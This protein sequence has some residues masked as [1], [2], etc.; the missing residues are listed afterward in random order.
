MRYKSISLLGARF[1]P[2]LLKLSSLS[3]A[4][5][6]ALFCFFAV[7]G[8][9][10][11]T[12]DS[13]VAYSLKELSAGDANLTI[14][15]SQVVRLTSQLSI[16]ETSLSKQTA[17]ITNRILSHELIYTQLSDPHGIRYFLG[18]SESINSGVK[19]LSGRLPSNCSPQ[20]C[21]VIQIGRSSGGVPRPNSVGLRIVGTGV[22]IN[23]LLFSGTMAPSA[24][25][26][27]LLTGDSAGVKT[28]AAFTNSH[29]SDAWVGSLD[30]KAI[31][32]LGVDAFIAK[33][34]VFED[35]LSIDY[36]ELI[37]TWPEDALSSAS[38]DA[39]ALKEKTSLLKFAI[40][41]LLLGYLVI[42]AYRQRRDHSRFR[43]SL[44]R[45][46]TPKSVITQ[47][48]ILESAVPIKIGILIALALSPLIPWV[49]GRF[50]YHSGYLQIFSGT[51]PFLLVAVTAFSLIVAITL[52]G[53][54]AWRPEQ[55]G[56]ILLGAFA[57]EGYLYLTHSSDSRYL[58]LPFLYLGIP[59][60]GVFIG[61]R[62][63]TPWL[64]PK[65]RL[66]FVIL[67]EF[68]SLWH[69]V[70]AT[71]ALAT[72]LAM[73]TLSF[74]SGVSAQAIASAHD[75]VPLDVALKTGPDLV[76]P[77]DL[78]G[79]KGYSQLVA[80]SH[81][82]GVLRTGTSIRGSGAV[83]D[84][85]SLIGTDPAA[86]STLVPDAQKMVKTQD[87][88]GSTTNVGL[89]IGKTKEISVDL[90]GIPPEIDLSAWVINSHG[91]HQNLVFEGSGLTRTLSIGKQL[92]PDSRLIAFDF[93]ES[94]NYL[95]RRLHA[96]GEGDYSVP[97]IKGVGGI[98]SLKFDGVE[99]NLPAEL[100]SNHNF[101]Y[102]FDGQS[103]YIQPKRSGGVPEAIVDPATA[104]LASQGVL[105]LSGAKNTYFQVTVGKVI[106]HF[107]SAGDRFVI[108]S[109]NQMQSELGISDLGSIDPIEVWVSTP[110]SDQY[111][112]RLQSGGFGGLV[113]QGSKA[114]EAE[115]RAN[116]RDQ[117]ILS[118]YTVALLFALFVALLV[119]VSALPLLYREG[120]SA[121]FYLESVGSTP[122]E[123][124]KALRSTLRIG[125]LV[126]LFLGGIMGIAVS[127][128]YISNSIPI[129][130]QTAV[131]FLLFVSV[132]V[133]GWG[134]TQ[135][136][137]RESNSVR[138]SS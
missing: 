15:S 80:G 115:Y 110:H 24:G 71:V 19:V 5:L 78:D 99:Q 57:F 27:L 28:L 116:P 94:S 81:A 63:L 16:I 45:V 43:E 119:V 18:A 9:S 102:D 129:V 89:S 72:L 66:S 35:Q 87:F 17:R 32:A 33:V 13:L 38:S 67:K 123:L 29:G 3:I 97:Q 84:S 52:V 1:R 65:R 104:A 127:R 107:P 14:N 47:E 41:T 117:G 85:L 42:V 103:I 21:E 25:N 69:G 118:A 137:F 8:S 138:S 124:R 75:V 128:T 96:N 39:I 55:R 86:I 76:K 98:N 134:F 56:F 30:L 59:V 100:W 131:L 10:H 44:S 92:S 64:A 22:I 105:T 31:S 95:S 6:F 126:G 73:A 112:K 2:N 68:F 122:S 82:Y 74:G 114:L 109:L 70:G 40:V 11:S 46:G 93:A 88:A 61:L 135:R 60:L 90:T 121:L 12:G 91:V 101:A 58:L 4:T 125:S 77:L 7:Q 36:P 108:M 48:L 37:V 20:M 50:G 132:E 106:S 133:I 54:R 130:E 62:L 113:I 26:A 83:S 53:D 49:L 111:I 51:A 34:V 136:F 79:L 23:P 120:K